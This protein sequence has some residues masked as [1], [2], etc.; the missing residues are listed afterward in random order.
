MCLFLYTYRIFLFVFFFFNDT[1]PTEIYT[2]S[3]H[4]AL[5]ISSPRL[6]MVILGACAEEV[7]KQVVLNIGPVDVVAEAGQL[8]DVDHALSIHR[9]DGGVEPG[10][11]G[12]VID[13]RMQQA[14]FVEA[15]YGRREGAHRVE[16]ANATAVDLHLHAER[17][18]EM[19]DL[20]QR[21]QAAHVAN[22]AAHDVARTSGDQVGA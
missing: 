1:A 12:V 2:L 7:L 19:A 6:L 8:R 5:P 3:L 9:V 18:G 15:A 11:G 16:I 21:R 4:D 22:A 10:R 20:H 14:A 13:E 17:L